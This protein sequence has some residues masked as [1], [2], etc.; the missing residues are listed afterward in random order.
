VKIWFLSCL[1]FSPLISSATDEWF[2]VEPE[3]IKLESLV[4]VRVK[5]IW[6]QKIA[7][8]GEA[9]AVT[10]YDEI[11]YDVIQLVEIEPHQFASLYLRSR[12]GDP[13]I[14]VWTN[15]ACKFLE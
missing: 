10:Y 6:Q 11:R 12:Y 9:S 1:L 13:I 4:E 7:C 5:N 14:D 3:L 8:V 15:V 2:E